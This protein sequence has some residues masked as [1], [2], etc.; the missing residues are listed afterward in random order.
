MKD[1]VIIQKVDVVKRCLARIQE[2]TK[3]DDNTLQD[4]NVQDVFVLNLQRAI[5]ASI[6]LAFVLISQHGW[7]LPKVYRESFQL[8]AD[9]EVIDFTLSE[10]MQKMCGFRNIAI[11]EYQA[12]D[13]DV[14]ESILK[15]HLVDIE[16]YYQSI[17]YWGK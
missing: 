4:I 3:G 8:L 6:D 7:P 16:E 1:D 2:V 17:M 10:K 14:L 5:Q 9:K 11:H 12:L 15:Y 13:L